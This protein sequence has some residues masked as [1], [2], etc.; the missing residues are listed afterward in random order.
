MPKLLNRSRIS[1]ST[2][3]SSAKRRPSARATTLRVMSSSVGPSPPVV[4]TTR[5][6][7]TASLINSSSR[8]SSSP[9]IVLSLT[10]IPRRLSC[11]VSQRLLVSVRSG[12]RSSEPMAM[13]SAVSMNDE[14]YHRGH[15]GRNSKRLVGWRILIF[16]AGQVKRSPIQEA[17]TGFVRAASC[18]FVDRSG[19]RN[20]IH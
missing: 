16:A 9:T 7:L 6:R 3:S 5:E 2:F 4:I 14:F 13:I 20:T 19:R 10:S 15:R 17:E 1:A 18:D 8:A 12:A 11:S